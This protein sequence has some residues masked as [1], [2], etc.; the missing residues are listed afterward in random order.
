MRIVFPGKT[1][2]KIPTENP[3][4]IRDKFFFPESLFYFIYLIEELGELVTEI[5]PQGSRIPENIKNVFNGTVLAL[6]FSR[7]YSK[8]IMVRVP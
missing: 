2:K 1:R 7:I 8:K 6:K 4:K 3:Q 5:G